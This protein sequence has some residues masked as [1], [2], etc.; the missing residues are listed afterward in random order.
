MEPQLF[1]VREIREIAGAFATMRRTGA[2][3]VVVL[4]DAVLAAANRQISVLATEHRLPA[5]YDSREYVEGG[6]LISYGPNIIEMVRRSTRLVDKI[7]KAANPADL[8][9]EQPAKF[10]LVINLKA[11]KALGLTIPPSVLA[12]ADE[13]IE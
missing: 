11:A 9:I 13:V 10:E 4:A 3:A 1:T 7:L 6:G 2:D 12:L 8:P 5:M